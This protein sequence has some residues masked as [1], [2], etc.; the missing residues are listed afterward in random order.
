MVFAVLTGGGSD[1]LTV[2]ATTN[3]DFLFGDLGGGMDFVDNQFDGDFP[4]DNNIFNL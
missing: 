1:I 4:F 3:V 2:E